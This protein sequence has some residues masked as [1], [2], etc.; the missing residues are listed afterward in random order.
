MISVPCVQLPS[1]IAT[2]QLALLQLLS[3]HAYQEIRYKCSSQ[4]G[5]RTQG[6][7]LV[8]DNGEAIPLSDSRV[9][10]RADGCQL[11]S[12]EEVC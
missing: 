8:G 6:L 5:T 11:S 2:D 7:R 12:L 9:K 10:V 3:I 1:L 4:A